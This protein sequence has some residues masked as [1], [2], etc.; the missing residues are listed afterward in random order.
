VDYYEFALS[1]SALVLG[2][3]VIL[4]I[5]LLKYYI[6]IKKIEEMTKNFKKVLK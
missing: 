6:E 5:I 3:Y 1:F 4:I 2:F